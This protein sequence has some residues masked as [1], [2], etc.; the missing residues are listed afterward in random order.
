MEAELLEEKVT[1]PVADV[2]DRLRNL[3]DFLPD[4]SKFVYRFARH[5]A[6]RLD[7]G[8]PCRDIYGIAFA[9]TA[10]H[11]FLEIR[12]ERPEN[13][14]HTSY[15]YSIQK[16]L[17]GQTQDHLF[18]LY[19][20][21]PKI[22]SAITQGSLEAEILAKFDLI[23]NTAI[24]RLDPVDD[25]KTAY[26]SAWRG[27]IFAADAL[28]ND[29]FSDLSFAIERAGIVQAPPLLFGY[30]TNSSSMTRSTRLFI[31]IYSEKHPGQLPFISYI[32]LK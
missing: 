31:P 9:N 32:K 25:A 13:D 12:F 23:T 27:E 11:A 30:D 10:L 8:K 19:A 20:K 18:E 1:Y 24:E 15:G 5:V 2:C 4:Q 16:S 22:F 28:E 29:G 6:D 14:V 17:F 3:K 7:S 26:R 21:L